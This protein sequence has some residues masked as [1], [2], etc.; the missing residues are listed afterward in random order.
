M[1]KRKAKAKR[2]RA[3]A[4]KKTTRKVAAKSKAKTKKKAKAKKRAKGTTNAYARKTKE[5][6]KRDGPSLHTNGFNLT[7]QQRLF[8][9]K[10]LCAAKLNATKAA[11]AAGYSRKSAHSQATA[12]MANPRVKQYL[13]K[14]MDDRKRRLEVNQDKVVSE[15]GALA[16]SRPSEFVE[17]VN[18]RLTVKDLDDVP[19]EL[20]GAI[21][22]YEPVFGTMGRSGIKVKFTDRVAP[23]K[24]IMQH[25]GMLQDKARE[26]SKGIIVKVFEGMHGAAEGLGED[27]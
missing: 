22:S 18:G 16:F 24:L 19:L 2:K 17:L 25:L 20:Q 14:R 23:L 26:S 7:D 12:L 27:K 10:Y 5:E 8:V 13:R 11:I 4:K 21:K 9:D 3:P 6:I 1:A 15:L